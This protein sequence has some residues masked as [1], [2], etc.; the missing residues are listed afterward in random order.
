MAE[1]ERFTERW[2]GAIRDWPG[3]LTLA[4]GLRDPVA[5]TDVLRGLQELRPGVRT[6]ELP[7][8]GHYP[9]IETP[10]AI[11]AALDAALAAAAG[12]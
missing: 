2:H 3:S 4:W 8:S 7:D 12:S 1:R 10:E 6:I 9:Q 5:R 11:G